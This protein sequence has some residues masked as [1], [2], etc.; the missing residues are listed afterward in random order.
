MAARITDFDVSEISVCN[1][2]TVHGT[3]VGDVTPI[4]SARN[5]DVKYFESQFSDGKKTV[6]V[7]SFEPNLRQ[8]I[9]T[10]REKGEQ[11]AISNCTV[12][13]RKGYE[14]NDLEIVV[15]SRG[16][17]IKSPKRFGIDP[18]T[19]IQPLIPTIDV[20]PLEKICDV[21]VNEHANIIGKVVH[22]RPIE[23]VRACGSS[24]TLHKEDVILA[25]N[26]DT[27]KCVAWEKNIGK[28]KVEHSY[29]YCTII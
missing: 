14:G 2:A 21:R 6:R 9:E 23:E 1:G 3:F 18:D 12:Q 28:L 16:N 17:L 8:K 26:S 4:K 10:A 5:S 20:S 29:S 27:C 19:C 24:K 25:D 22:T 15:G 7:V 11:V 13:K